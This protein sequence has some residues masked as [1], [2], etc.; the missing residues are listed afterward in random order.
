DLQ[1][2]QAKE[3]YEQLKD[4]IALNISTAYLRALLA[5]EQINN[6]LYQIDL[7]QNNKQRVEKLL[8]LGRSN[9]LELSQSESQLANDSSLYIQAI[10]NY[11]LSIIELK[12]IL[13]L[14]Y[15]QP[16]VIAV[17]DLEGFQNLRGLF[18]EKPNPET[19]YN[20]ALNDFHSIKAS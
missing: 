13:N 11:E 19:I 5:L 4:D 3:N 14:D 16:F 8:E 20:I 17:G 10:L 1:V 6:I 12:T 9:I 15:Q 7:S 2:L 18:S